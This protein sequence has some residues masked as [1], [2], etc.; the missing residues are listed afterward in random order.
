MSAQAK[1][2]T[3]LPNN[4][5]QLGLDYTGVS[6]NYN[7]KTNSVGQAENAMDYVDIEMSFNAYSE[8][9][10]A[11]L[12]IP[13]SISLL[14]NTWVVLKTRTPINNTGH[15]AA[16]N[17]IDS[18]TYRVPGCDQIV[19]QGYNLVNSLLDQCTSPERRTELCRLGGSPAYH[20]ESYREGAEANN[21]ND[22]LY[23][24]LIL[25]DLP[26]NRV[27]PN[28]TTFPYPGHMTNAPLE[29]NLKLTEYSKYFGPNAVSYLGIRFI[30]RKLYPETQYKRTTYRYQFKGYTDYMHVIP[31]GANQIRLTGLKAG[32]ITQFRFRW[33]CMPNTKYS[34]D[35]H[36]NIHQG[37]KQKNIW[38]EYAGNVIWKAPGGMQAAF[39]TNYNKISNR[40]DP[41]LRL[42]FVPHAGSD[43]TNLTGLGVNNS[44]Y[45]TD[46]MV[47]VLLPNA[48][49]ISVA[50]AP[51]GNPAARPVILADSVHAPEA[52]Q[53]QDVELFPDRN[54]SWYWY[55]IPIAEALDKWIGQNG[56]ALGADFKD[57]DVTLKW[58]PTVDGRPTHALYYQ[59]S[60]N[61]FMQFNGD[62][63]DLA[64]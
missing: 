16:Y 1:F 32:E 48:N 54:A 51:V 58:T 19:R 45:N 31:Q 52:G 7:D 38:L 42:G 28:T 12:N 56:Y 49:V 21:I 8:S 35:Y 30:G 47:N 22:G 2:D 59:T 64:Q 61:S 40:F 41:P 4:T 55:T 26:W 62:T 27:E 46:V 18:Y 60:L 43:G 11:T 37:F 25:L 3:V 29:L 53:S 34:T 13:P 63:V 6:T 9:T 14:G 44:I 17:I 5:I 33:G 20:S 15:F 50:R 36:Y 23:E 39:D 24:Y 57:A 10:I